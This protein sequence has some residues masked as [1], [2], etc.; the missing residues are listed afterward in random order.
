[1]NTPTLSLPPLRGEDEGEGE[2][3]PVLRTPLCKRGRRDT[4]GIKR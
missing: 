2:E 4:E 3:H 1:M